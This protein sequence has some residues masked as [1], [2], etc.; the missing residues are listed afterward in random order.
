LMTAVTFVIAIFVRPVDV[1]REDWQT[2][3]VT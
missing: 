1:T 3:L 2:A